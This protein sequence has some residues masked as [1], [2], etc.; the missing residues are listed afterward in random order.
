MSQNK[1]IANPRQHKNWGKFIPKKELL[2]E[3]LSQGQGENPCLKCFFALQVRVFTH[4]FD[5]KDGVAC[6]KTEPLRLGFV[7]FLLRLTPCKPLGRLFAKGS[8]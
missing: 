5:E 2:N 8:K 3:V 4:F 6:V 1:K 7:D